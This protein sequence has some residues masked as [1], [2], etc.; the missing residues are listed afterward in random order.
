MSHPDFMIAQNLIRN[1]TPFA[2]LIMAAMQRAVT[3]NLKTLIHAWPELSMEFLAR[4]DAPGGY[5]E[6]ELEAMQETKE[7]DG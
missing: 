3:H 6:G 1:E 5:L 4:H 2:A 7:G